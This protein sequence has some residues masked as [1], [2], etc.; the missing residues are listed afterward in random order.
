MGTEL[1]EVFPEIWVNNAGIGGMSTL[2]HRVL[3]E[4]HIKDLRPD[5]VLFLVGLND[6][7]SSAMDWPRKKFTTPTQ[8][9]FKSLEPYSEVLHIAMNVVRTRRVMDFTGQPDLDVRKVGVLEIPPETQQ[10]LMDRHAQEFLGLYHTRLTRLI[11]ISRRL[12]MEPVL[13]TQPALYGPVID[14]ATNVDLSVVPVDGLP[15]GVKWRILELYNQI[16]RNVGTEQGV[17]V[18][19]LGRQLP[20]NSRYY[21]DWVHFTNEGAQLVADI[22][23]RDLCP[24]LSERYQTF[25]GRNCN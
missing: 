12:G 25:P 7:A 6:Q 8:R 11:T 22:I 2:G 9:F 3:L 15:G 5:V 17:L 4:D 10:A 13:V 19:E 21:Y 16:T 18:I 14:E 23:N 1:G 24:W 20:K